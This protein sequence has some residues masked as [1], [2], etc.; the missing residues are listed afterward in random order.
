MY[1]FAWRLEKKKYKKTVSEKIVLQT[2]SWSQ[3]K[4]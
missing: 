3:Q 1:D 4:Q 2:V